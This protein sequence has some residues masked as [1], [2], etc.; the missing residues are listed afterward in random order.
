MAQPSMSESQTVGETAAPEFPGLGTRSGTPPGP[1][2]ATPL[3]YMRAL[4]SEPLL[5]LSEMY[6]QY[7]DTVCLRSPG[8]ALYMVF[9]PEDLRHILQTNSRNYGKGQIFRRIM[10]TS[11][12]GLVFIDGDL[13]QEQRRLSQPAFK[14]DRLAK[15]VPDM[16]DAAVEMGQEWDATVPSGEVD[17]LEA[18]IRLTLQISGRGL[19]GLPPHKISDDF[20]WGLEEY[21]A[22]DHYLTTSLAPVPLSIPSVRNRR[23][24]RAM[25]IVDETIYELIEDR[26]RS[27][28]DYGDLLSILVRATEN[29]DLMPVKRLRDELVTFLV[30][31][32]E[33]SALALTWVFYFLSRHPEQRE[34]LH[35]ELDRV[36]GGRTPTAEDV[37]KLTHLTNVILETLRLAP[38]PAFLAREPFEA[39]TVHGW[40]LPAKSM[41]LL[42]PFITHRH[43]DFWSN[44]EGFDPDRFLDPVHTDRSRFAFIPF[45]AGKRKCIGDDFAML[46]M[47]IVVASLCQKYVLDI[48]PGQIVEQEVVF[49]LRPKHGMHMRVQHRS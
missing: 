39:D 37:P 36:L 5:F 21:V 19:L 9:H 24:H 30:A 29:S 43:P 4:A 2:R 31:G 13:W 44:P 34:R 14:R 6:R 35:E 7:G 25:R 10:R 22:Y 18:M 47:K 41:M 11:G 32:H 17:L 42:S 40:P 1:Y 3:P 46:E 28:E 26:K 33:T 12:E 20:L 8:F 16:A 45:G 27:S 23:M 48:S 15:L 49:A 38:P